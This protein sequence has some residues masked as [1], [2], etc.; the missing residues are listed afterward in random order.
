MSANLHTLFEDSKANK[1]ESTKLPSQQRFEDKQE[2]EIAVLVNIINNAFDDMRNQVNDIPPGYKNHLTKANRMNEQIKG[3]L[4]DHYGDRVKQLSH[5]RFGLFLND[6]VLLFK[7]FTNKGLPSNIR[8]KNSVMLSTKGKL[9]FPGEPEI[10]FIGFTVSPGYELLRTIKAV[11]IVDEVV[12][13]S[14][15]LEGLAG[16][17]RRKTP[18]VVAPTGGSLVVKPKLQQQKKT[19]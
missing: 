12:Q 19:G 15:N 11:K 9:N 4:T 2:Q 1:P 13:W 16:D 5:N 18:I 7:K 3:K 14:L 17:I 10:V 6:Y 8:T